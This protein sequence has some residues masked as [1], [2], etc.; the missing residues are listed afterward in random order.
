[1]RRAGQ[2]WNINIHYDALLESEVPLAA[3][4]VL[5]VGCGDGFLA[6]RL[7]RRVPDAT[8]LDLDGPVLRRAQAR[9]A[10][11]RIR[12][13]HGDVMTADLPRA[14]FDAVLSKPPYTTSRTRARHWNAS[15]V[16]SARAERWPSSPL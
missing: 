5:D 7:T 3:R 11:R 10:A 1:V 2:P 4:R 8:A 15:A 16:W 9:F 13:V 14:G 12:W 6:A